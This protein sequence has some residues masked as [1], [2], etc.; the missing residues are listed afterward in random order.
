MHPKQLP[1]VPY[2]P[3]YDTANGKLQHWPPVAVVAGATTPRLLHIQDRASGRSFL[4]DTGAEVSLIPASP[5]DNHAANA[6]THSA[7][8][9]A[10]NGTEIKTY[11]TRRIPLQFG[12][13][14]FQGSLIVADVNQAILGAA[15]LHGNG[16]LVDL[17]GQRRV[18]SATYNTIAAPSMVCQLVPLAV[19]KTPQI[20]NIYAN[21][22]ASWPK[23]TEL[24]FRKERVPH[25][26][27]LCIDTG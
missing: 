7:P 26:V 12:N 6:S 10:A 21:L 20:N 22:L 14:H 25:G 24:S 4:I 17:G 8:L 27:E 16:L 23:L 13:K 5:A 15:F 1:D 3:S 19:I 9:M 2:S 11:G 18:H